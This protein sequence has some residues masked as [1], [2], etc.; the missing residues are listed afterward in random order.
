M[1]DWSQSDVD[2]LVKSMKKEMV[3][4]QKQVQEEMRE[5]AKKESDFPNFKQLSLFD[6]RKKNI[7]FDEYEFGI[8]GAMWHSI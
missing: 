2:G 4:E 7:F 8:S 5:I 6:F 1:L 3:K